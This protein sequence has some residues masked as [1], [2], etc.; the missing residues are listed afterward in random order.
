V[1]LKDL[2]NWMG[3]G[4]M[5]TRLGRSRQGV[6][7]LLDEGRIRAVKTPIGWLADPDAVERFAREHGKKGGE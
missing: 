4:Q 7:N 3:V 1:K 6:I 5:S 2:K